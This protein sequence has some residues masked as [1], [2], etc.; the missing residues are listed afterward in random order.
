MLELENEEATHRCELEMKKIELD[1]AA[2]ST[3]AVEPE[4][5]SK[6]RTDKFPK[7]PKFQ[8]G[9]DEINSHLQRFERFTTSNS[10]PKSEWATALSAL[11]T[12]KAL[13]VYSKMPD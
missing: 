13:D 2:V 12:R 6:G 11:L 8:D 7:L 1:A 10:W 9:I 3:R 5:G 4:P